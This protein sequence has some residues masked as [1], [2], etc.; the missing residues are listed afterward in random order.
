MSSLH[1]F[2]KDQNEEPERGEWMGADKNS[3]QEFGLW[4]QDHSDATV[5]IS[6]QIHIAS[7]VLLDLGARSNQQ[8][9]KTRS[10]KQHEH[11]SWKPKPVRQVYKISQTGPLGLSLSQAGETG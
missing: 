2:L 5:N 6:H 4:P 7:K 9:L 1:D 10:G 11:S 8:P 3:T